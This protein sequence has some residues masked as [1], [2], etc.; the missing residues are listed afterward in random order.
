MNNKKHIFN[1]LPIILLLIS[2]NSPQEGQDIKIGNFTFF[3]II[4]LFSIYLLWFVKTN[5]NS[6]IDKKIFNL[7][8]WYFLYLISE[9]LRGVIISDNY[10]DY[11][12][13]L[14]NSMALFIP[15]V[16]YCA[17]YKI[18]IHNFFNFYI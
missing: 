4:Q 1:L 18:L 12:F 14:K 3:L 9:I 6:Q 11:K 17:N 8:N 16:A 2:I 7:F 15:L 10:C 13:I 5:T